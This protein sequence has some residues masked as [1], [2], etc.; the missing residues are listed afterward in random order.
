MGWLFLI[1]TLI[2]CTEMLCYKIKGWHV[3]LLSGFGG[4]KQARRHVHFGGVYGTVQ[5]GGGYGKFRG[6][7]LWYNSGG[8]KY[9]SGAF[10]YVS[11][12]FRWT[13]SGIFFSIL[14]E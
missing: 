10:Q 8:F 3:S 14:R 9:T 7:D 4:L 6:G 2:V 12:G 5:G 13:F 1:W 11:S